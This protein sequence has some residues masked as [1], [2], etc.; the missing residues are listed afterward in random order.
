MSANPVGNLFIDT[1]VLV[2]A[3]DRSAGKK[4][5]IGAQLMESCWENGN[6]CLSI[7]VLQEFL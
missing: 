5:A 4:Q 7:Q 2:Y 3:Y 6:G 1:T